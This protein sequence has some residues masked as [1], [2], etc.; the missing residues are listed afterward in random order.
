MGGVPRVTA[1]KYKQFIYKYYNVFF[2]FLFKL[3]TDNIFFL[4]TFL[5]LLRRLALSW[6]MSLERINCI[7]ASKNPQKEVTWGEYLSANWDKA[8]VLEIWG[9]FIPAHCHYSQFHY[10]PEYM[11][12]LKVDFNNVTDSDSPVA[13][14][15]LRNTPFFHT[16]PFCP[17]LFFIHLA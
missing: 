3:R 14:V 8:P 5:C 10:S 4:S 13:C 6:R 15:C 17:W 2:F 9:E 16:S 1:Q 12:G 11:C 7:L